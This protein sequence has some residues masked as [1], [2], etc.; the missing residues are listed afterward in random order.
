MSSP[1]LRSIMEL[2]TS[3]YYF[4]GGGGERARL[5]GWRVELFSAVLDGVQIV[6]TRRDAKLAVLVRNGFEIGQDGI[7]RAG[8]CDVCAGG[9]GAIPSVL[10][11]TFNYS[12]R[13][14]GR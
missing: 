1:R 3:E 13:P 14:E 9:F 10:S 4:P 7:V 12:R 6:K 8:I 11:V 2:H 5:G